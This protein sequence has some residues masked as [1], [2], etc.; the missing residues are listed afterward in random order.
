M[1]VKES[2]LPTVGVGLVIVRSCALIVFMFLLYEDNF[3]LA[4][5]SKQ[6]HFE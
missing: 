4:L 3:F 1:V 5:Y 2:F 6:F